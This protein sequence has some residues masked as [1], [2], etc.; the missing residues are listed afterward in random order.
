MTPATESR[1]LDQLRGITLIGPEADS[2]LQSLT[3]NDM[4]EASAR[5][6]AW[7]A[8]TNVKGRVIAVFAW[9]Q[10]D[11]GWGLAVPES[12]A[13]AVH[14]YLVRM[15]FRRQVVISAP[16]DSHR[17]TVDWADGAPRLALE[18]IVDAAPLEDGG[19]RWEQYLV[20]RGIPQLV[21]ETSELFLPQSLNLEALGALS[22]RKGCYPGQEVVVRTQHLGTIKRVLVRGPGTAPPGTPL[23]IRSDGQEL[24]AGR[25][26]SSVGG[27][28]LAVVPVELVGK[29]QLFYTQSTP[30]LPAGPWTKL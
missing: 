29:P 17:V 4:R 23:R 11:Q 26:V 10:L 8:I 2:F 18:T 3:T 14:Q 20:E 22:F 25:V 16:F 6:P 24:D 13:A 15:K 30:S 19:A 5:Y 1:R 27:Q 9:I 12:L 21:R 28:M 7:G